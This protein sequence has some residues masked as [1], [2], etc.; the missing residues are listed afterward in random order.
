[1]APIP[2]RPGST[3]NTPAVKAR[4]ER[5]RRV[6]L[7]EMMDGDVY[8]L[9]LADMGPTDDLICRRSTGF[10]FQEFLD[11]WS[12]LSILVI[13]WFARRKAGE[14]DLTFNKVAAGYDTDDSIYAAVARTDLVDEGDVIEVG[15]AAPHPLPDAGS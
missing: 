7:V 6:A 8:Q 14:S 12:A 13:V 1:M 9:H 5:R 4:E 10:P 15:E 2:P 3:P 11:R